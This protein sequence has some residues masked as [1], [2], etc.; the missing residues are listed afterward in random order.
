MDFLVVLL[1]V[2]RPAAVFLATV[3]S[4][5]TY[6][7]RLLLAWIHPRG[8]VAAAIASLFALEIAA[9]AGI[10]GGTHD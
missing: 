4:K 2:I 7:E 6:A 1:F 5:L 9:V 8:I 3:G 10:D